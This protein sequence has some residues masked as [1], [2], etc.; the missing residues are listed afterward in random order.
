MTQDTRSSEPVRGIT[1][2]ASAAPSYQLL[3][4]VAHD[5]RSPL[6]SIL[7]LVEAL[8][9][10]HSG[11]V[12][13]RQRRQLSLIYTATFALNNL[14]DDLT[15][16]AQGG[17]LSLLEREP[18]RFSL[19]RVCD[20]VCDLVLPIV[21]ARGVALGVDHRAADSRIGHPAALTRVLLNLVSNALRVT[22]RGSVTIATGERGG[23][24]VGISVTDTGP[25]ISAEAMVSLF[26]PL[27]SRGP[28]RRGISTSGLGLAISR[29]I[30]REMGGTIDVESTVGVGPRFHFTLPLPRAPAECE[31]EN[32]GPEEPR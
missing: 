24:E 1:D 2:P 21:E 22:T 4:E 8:R 7:F 20:T 28:E 5:V 9:A 25:G 23:D 29:R 3:A 10:G 30:V 19:R 11:R 6:T 17:G 26:Q 18:I 15:E 32:P 31:A 13:E 27:E 16:L 12:N 14:V